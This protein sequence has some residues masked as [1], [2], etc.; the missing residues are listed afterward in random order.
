MIANLKQVKAISFDLDDT[1]WDCASAIRGA[2]RS[3]YEWLVKYAPRVTESVDADALLRRRRQVLE[4]QPELVGDVTRL[5]KTMLEQTLAEFDYG[6]EVAAAAFNAFYLAR[7]QV[8]LYEGCIDLLEGLS[9]QYLVAAITNGNADL[10]LV[11]IDHHFQSVH[12]ADLDNPAKPH[13]HMFDQCLERFNL[14]ASALLH[15][16]DNPEADVAGAQAIG[17]QAVWFN[18]QKIPW[19]EAL[20]SAEFEVESL[21]ELHE[22]LLSTA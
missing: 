19:P 21:G 20:P 7:S 8:Q 11:G 18:S 1:L 6:S 9:P 15:I 13:R 3:C 22:L 16:G 14:P 4:H 5:R 17:A 2:E 12:M 10:S